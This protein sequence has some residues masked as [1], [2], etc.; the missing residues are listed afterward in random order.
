M[1]IYRLSSRQDTAN[2]ICVGFIRGKLLACLTPTSRTAVGE[3]AGLHLRK[4]LKFCKTL[5][6]LVIEVFR[7]LVAGIF[8][9]PIYFIVV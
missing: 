1:V 2:R 6:S 3:E 4:L 5:Q 8:C 9:V 7:R